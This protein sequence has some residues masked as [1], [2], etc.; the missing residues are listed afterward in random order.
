M[1]CVHFINHW[2]WTLFLYITCSKHMSTWKYF[3]YLRTLTDDPAG[4]R[5]C[6]MY[7]R[8]G[9]LTLLII[10]KFKILGVSFVFW[11]L[12]DLGFS[13]L[14]IPLFVSVSVL[15]LVLLSC[16]VCFIKFAVWK[17]KTLTDDHGQ[18]MCVMCIFINHWILT[19]LLY[20]SCLK[21]MSTWKYFFTFKLWPMITITCVLWISKIIEFELCFI[22][23]SKLM[24]NWKYIF[25]YVLWWMKKL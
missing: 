4:A 2:I 9:F 21:R 17:R 1:C 25:T 10:C 11:C 12:V 6:D 7:G 13:I 24:I 20:I 3:F 8:L 16:W 5:R 19:L 15:L 18:N 23:C 22:S 14:E